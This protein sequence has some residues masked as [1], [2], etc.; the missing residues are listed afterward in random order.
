[1]SKQKIYIGN[2]EVEFA[3]D[4]NIWF[5]QIEKNDGQLE[6]SINAEKHGSEIDWS[7]IKGFTTHFMENEKTYLEKC[8]E[9]LEMLARMTTFFS[10]EDV[11]CGEFL[12]SGIEILD[13]Q[14]SLG[15]KWNFELNFEFLD[16]DPYGIWIVTFYQNSI[17]GIRREQQ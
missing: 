1:M 11:Q 12:F 3:L 13:N 14:F 7:K 10:D 8:Y 2:Q 5:C 6:I 16:T 17:T 15:D 4:E 9:P